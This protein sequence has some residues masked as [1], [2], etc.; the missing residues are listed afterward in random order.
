[1]PNPLRNR[2]DGGRETL[3]E[4]V[5]AACR[6]DVSRL[7]AED[8]GDVLMGTQSVACRVVS[9]LETLWLH[10]V[11]KIRYLSFFRPLPF[12]SLEIQLKLIF[13]WVEPTGRRRK[14]Y[15]RL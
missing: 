7:V 9:G 10:L 14:R 13:W 8:K 15:R 5:P 6:S 2:G 11:G 12:G 1:M 4:E 3:K